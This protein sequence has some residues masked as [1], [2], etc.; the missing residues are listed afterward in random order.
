MKFI[1]DVAVIFCYANETAGFPF[2][3]TVIIL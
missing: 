2:P 3:D 1:F